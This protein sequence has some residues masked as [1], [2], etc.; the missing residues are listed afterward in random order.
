MNH[1]LPVAVVR[2]DLNGVQQ[3][4][5][6]SPI[7]YYF[8]ENN[9]TNLHP[10][11]NIDYHTFMARL[12]QHLHQGLNVYGDVREIHTDF[13]SH[14]PLQERQ[15]TAFTSIIGRHL[16]SPVFFS[17]NTINYY[18]LHQREQHQNNIEILNN[19]NLQIMPHAFI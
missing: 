9:D 13:H 18:I 7:H 8:I 1:S 5:A 11:F 10:M 15:D 14:I 17:P 3:F 19:I 16:A 6:W 2:F 4:R 12:Y